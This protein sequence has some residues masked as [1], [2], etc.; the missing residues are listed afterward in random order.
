MADQAD[1]PQSSPSPNSSVT[2]QEALEVVV[3][4]TKH[5]RYRTLC[6]DS[7][8]ERHHYRDA[9]MQLALKQRPDWVDT[10]TAVDGMV[11]VRPS[12]E[13][14]G[15]AQLAR[16]AAG[17]VGRVVS[18]AVRGEPVLASPEL[19]ATRLSVCQGGCDYY[20][21]GQVRCKAAGCGCFLEAKT[22]LATERCPLGKW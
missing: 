22:G 3:A 9:V 1:P 18:A 5:E 4:R 7:H 2:W 11:N 12:G 10:G 13:Y 8:P 15:I 17:A 19:K 14:P 20:D 21:L 16:N 6:A